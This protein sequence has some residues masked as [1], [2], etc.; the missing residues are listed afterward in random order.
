MID[1][2]TH[3]AIDKYEPVE[4]V[5]EA[6]ESSGIT[7]AVLV[8]HLGQ[9]DNTY[10]ETVVKDNPETFTGVGLVDT[11]DAN[12][13]KGTEA[14]RTSGSFMGIRFSS[15]SILGNCDAVMEAGR[16]GLNLILYT[17][18]GVDEVGQEIANLA[19]K[20]PDTSIVLTHLGCPGPK[21]DL[22]RSNNSI[23]S[24]GEYPNIFVGLSGQHMFGEYPYHDLLDYTKRI[25]ET[26][27]SKRIMWGSN[28]PVCGSVEAYRSD[29][30]YVSSENLE[31]SDGE[32]QDITENTAREV[33]FP[34]S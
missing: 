7:K 12:W 9:F 17:P 29:L 13:Y 26:Y 14:L 30:S 8:Q 1:S 3:C 21:V 34:G 32:V 5:V 23:F 31:L 27:T 33:F 10:I 25:V 4:S 28:F 20:V 2:Y 6:M 11:T 24:L 18:N 22:N 15:M 19:R 16:M